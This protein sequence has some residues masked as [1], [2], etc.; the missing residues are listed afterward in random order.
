MIGLSYN[1][2][3]IAS[4]S[5][6]SRIFKKNVSIDTAHLFI[7]ARSFLDI[8]QSARD[9]SA[10]D[11]SEPSETILI[12]NDSVSCS[13]ARFSYKKFTLISMLA[14]LSCSATQPAHASPLP[15]PHLPPLNRSSECMPDSH[16]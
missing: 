16:V 8:I 10:D 11:T 2:R 7:C 5:L 6:L 12:S 3:G 9:G 15:S 4:K 1:Q 14:I 13:L